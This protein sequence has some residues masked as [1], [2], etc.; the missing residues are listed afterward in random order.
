MTSED[1]SS[2]LRARGKYSRYFREKFFF[3]IMTGFSGLRVHT[4]LA[5]GF[6]YLP[7]SERH[8]SETLNRNYLLIVHPLVNELALPTV[9][10]D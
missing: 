6:K 2:P 5:F 4:W 8:L 7:V 9:R 1:G 10:F 3:V